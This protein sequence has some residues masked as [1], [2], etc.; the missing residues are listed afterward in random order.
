M[1]VFVLGFL[2][3]AT[4]KPLEINDFTMHLQNHISGLLI[5]KQQKAYHLCFA[6]SDFIIGKISYMYLKL[7]VF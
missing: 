5:K 4:A 1:Y 7:N 3:L 2:C 6:V